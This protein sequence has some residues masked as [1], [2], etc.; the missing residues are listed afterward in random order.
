MSRFKVG[1]RVAW[2]VGGRRYAG[3][4]KHASACGRACNV[5]SREGYV[6]LLRTTELDRVA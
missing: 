5:T 2:R 3:R 4:V 6:W 1:D